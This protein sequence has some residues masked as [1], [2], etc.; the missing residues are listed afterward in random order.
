MLT[1]NKNS[2]TLPRV[3]KSQFINL[4]RL[5]LEYDRTQG[6]Y[7]ISNYNN[8]KKLIDA[9]SSILNEEKICFLQ[10]CNICN[11][12]FP[13]SSCKYAESCTTKDLPFEC[14]CQNCLKKVTNCD[15]KSAPKPKKEKTP[16]TKI[17]QKLM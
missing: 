17:Q 4:L 8:T 5:G 15:S 7:R 3:E 16:K 9:L 10:K 11:K 1:L 14:V 2:F 6:T 13:C 12:Y